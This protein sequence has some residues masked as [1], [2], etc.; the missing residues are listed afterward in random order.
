METADSLEGSCPSQN[1]AEKMQGVAAV[2]L[3]SLGPGC[4]EAGDAS[5]LSDR[6]DLP[7]CTH[8]H[9]TRPLV[10]SY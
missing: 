9:G 6:S 4:E 1:R 8:C 5:G 7:S 2:E 3:V 10:L